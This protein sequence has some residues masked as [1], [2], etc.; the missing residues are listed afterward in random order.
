MTTRTD[1]LVPFATRF[2]ADDGHGEEGVAV[3]EWHGGELE[4]PAVGERDAPAP[5]LAF[6]RG[7]AH[8]L[9]DD[10]GVVRILEL[11]GDMPGHRI[12]AGMGG[13]L[14]LLE[15]PQLAEAVVPEI[16]APIREIGRAN[17]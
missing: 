17:V 14:F 2:R 3:G 8:Q 12:D 6:D 1:T 5:L 11:L 10:P 4:I 13:E 7:A 16:E 9:P 15:I